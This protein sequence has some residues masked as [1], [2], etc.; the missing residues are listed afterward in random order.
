MFLRDLCRLYA[1]LQCLVWHTGSQRQWSWQADLHHNTK[2]ID[3][4]PSLSAM[5]VHFLSLGISWNK[6]WIISPV[7]A[8]QFTPHVCDSIASTL[9]SS[10]WRAFAKI[11]VYSLKMNTKAKYDAVG[12]SVVPHIHP[13]RRSSEHWHQMGGLGWLVGWLLTVTA[14]PG[15]SA[16]CHG[17]RGLDP[18]PAKW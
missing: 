4:W 12:T 2:P 1:G 8:H 18:L 6:I 3:T 14:L 17:P 7:T 9:H 5:T 16:A 13:P 10:G 11:A 15:P